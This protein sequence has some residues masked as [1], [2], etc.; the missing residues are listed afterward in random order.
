MKLLPI[1][2][3]IKNIWYL[4][5]L[6]FKRWLILISC[7]FPFTA[8][9][10]VS[11]VNS[12]D[13]AG[14]TYSLSLLRTEPTYAQP[15]QLWQFVSDLSVS[16]PNF[17]FVCSS[18][19]GLIFVV[20]FYMN[21]I[22]YVNYQPKKQ[23][24][25]K[26]SVPDLR[27]ALDPKALRLPNP[28]STCHFTKCLIITD[29]YRL[30]SPPYRSPTTVEPTPSSWFLAPPYPTPST[31]SHLPATQRTLS[32]LSSLSDSNRS[33][34]QSALDLLFLTHWPWG[35]Q[36]VMGN[37]WGMRGC[38]SQWVWDLSNE[39]SRKSTW[40]SISVEEKVY[41]IEIFQRQNTVVQCNWDQ[42]FDRLLDHGCLIITLKPGFSLWQE[43][44]QIHVD[45]W[46]SMN[47]K[48]V[49]CSF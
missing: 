25:W 29:L 46:S 49:D 13:H 6:W 38:S 15:E 45:T 41:C 4:L 9:D 28:V 39:T 7:Y 44:C 24:L 47:V 48:I 30:F 34:N 1:D 23:I 43:A 19:H 20:S 3:K 26:I 40:R 11:T 8:T 5:C 2:S 37:V 36:V 21:M 33:V 31:A 10:V 17:S 27:F 16:C 32:P 14:I 42:F 35:N 18:D 22:L 12:I